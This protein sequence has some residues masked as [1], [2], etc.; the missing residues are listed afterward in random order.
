MAIVLPRTGTNRL[1]DLVS[2]Y[3]PDD[4]I[5]DLCPRQFTGGRRCALSAPQ[6]WRAH[7]L[8][9]LTSTHSLNLVTAQLPEQPAWRRFCRLRGHW[10]KVRMLH[11]FRRQIGVSGLRRINQHLLERLL[12]RQG[13]QPHAV[14]LMDA[15]DLPAACSGFKK[16]HRRLHRRPRSLGWAHPQ[17]RPKPLV[18]RLQETHAA[19]VAADHAPVGDVGAAGQLAGA[20]QRGRR[21][22]VGAQPALVCAAPRLV[23]G[24]GRRRHGLSGRP[25]QAGGARTMAERGGDQTACGH[26]TLAALRHGRARRMSAG[27]TAGVVGARTANGATMVS[28]GERRNAMPRLLA[29]QRLPA[30]FRVFSRGARNPVWLAAAGQPTRPVAVAASPSVDRTG[31]V[32]REES[33][34]IGSDV[35]QQPAAGV[36][37]ELVGRQRGAVTYDGVVGCADRKAFALASAAAPDGIGLGRRT[38]TPNE[39][40]RF[41]SAK[42]EITK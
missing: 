30:A 25:K 16:K 15:T 19:A 14:A 2:L 20:R 24:T 31:A 38:M 40:S 29:G 23:A 32:L 42:R 21:W 26:E 3:V 41:S 1:L 12:R 8:P 10:P 28:R 36:A 37:N 18:R 11:E 13:V 33:T 22:I 17:D 9:L 4:F 27:G 6:L 34:R 5:H 7:L 39:Q 35:L